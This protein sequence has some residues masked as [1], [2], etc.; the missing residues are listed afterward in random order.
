[1]SKLYELSNHLQVKV[2][3]NVKVLKNK[4]KNLFSINICTKFVE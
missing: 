1:M 4:K 3:L 2:I